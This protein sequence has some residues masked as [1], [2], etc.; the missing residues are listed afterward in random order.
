MKTKLFIFITMIFTSLNAQNDKA[1]WNDLFSYS[2]VKLLE[3]VNGVIYCGTENG[4]FLFNPK[5]PTNDWIKLNKTNFLNNVGVSAMAYDKVSDS[6]LVGYENGGLD[7]LKSGESTMVLDI[8]WNGFSGDKKVNH[9]FINDGIAFISG[10]FGIV[11]YSLKDEEFKETTRINSEVVN[12][13]RIKEDVLYIAT[14]KGIYSSDLSDKKLNNPNIKLWTTLV[15]GNVSNIELFN[16]EIYYS[17]NNE[18]KTISGTPVSG[19][20]NFIEDLKL[21]NEK[22]IITQNNQISV[23][24]SGDYSKSEINF[25]TAISIDNIVYGGSVNHGIIN[26]SNLEEFYPDGPFNNKAWSVTTKNGKVWIAPGGMGD[27]YNTPAENVDGFSYY[28]SKNWKHFS[29]SKIKAKDIVQVEVNPLDDNKFVVGSYNYYVRDVDGRRDVLEFNLADNDEPK[30]ILQKNDFSSSRI[31]GLNYDLLGNLYVA[32]SFPVDKAAG[33][34][35]PDS[36]FN[37]YARRKNGN[38]SWEI[39]GSE[40]NIASTAVKPIAGS[41]YTFF[42]NARYGGISVVDNSNFKEIVNIKVANGDLPSDDVHTVS[43]DKSGNLWIGTGQGLVVLY[44]ADNAVSSNNIIA[45]PVVIIQDGI[46]EALLTDVG[47]YAIKVDNANNKWIATNGAGVYYVSDSGETTKLHFTSKNSPLP[48]DVVYDVSIDESTGKVFFATEKGVV[49]YNGD[50]STEANNF[51]NAIAYPNPYRPEYKGNVTI[52]NLPNRALVKITDIVG[53]LLFEKKA[54]GGV[55]EWNTNNSKGK[56]VA[57]GIYL[58]LMTNADGTETK[59]LKI[60]VVR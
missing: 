32:A 44:G 7:L 34:G 41:Q 5:N 29:F 39:I 18:L 17:V 26:L 4:I 56:P 35:Y 14:D 49:S 47:I 19:A 9:I 43:L 2:N 36:K 40:K 20:F 37:Y 22:L 57:S 51:N 38:T 53:N 54:D 3:E 21:S 52:K 10:A 45:E 8:K 60:A 11:S 48:S 58:V 23:L 13:A 31:A 55:I 27:V 12:D 25:N 42:P 50:V 6:F 16:N 33:V 28:D 1:R 59:T 15:S 24:G 46:P 30:I